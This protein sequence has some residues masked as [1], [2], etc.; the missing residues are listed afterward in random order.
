M[1]TK[2]ISYFSFFLALLVGMLLGA[3]SS[4]E[5]KEP[6]PNETSYSQKEIAKVLPGAWLMI[7]DDHNWNRIDFTRTNNKEGSYVWLS[8]QSQ[9]PILDFEII[10]G[11][12]SFSSSKQ[13]ETSVFL[14]PEFGSMES[15][16]KLG[17]PTSMN[18]LEITWKFTEGTSNLPDKQKTCTF[19]RILATIFGVRDSEFEIDLTSLL[20]KKEYSF[21]IPENQ[22]I[23]TMDE[24]SSSKI[25]IQGYG[26][27]YIPVFTEDGIG[28][29]EVTGS[30]ITHIP[31][32]VSDYY[33]I[34]GWYDSLE[35]FF[36]N[37]HTPALEQQYPGIE[38][39]KTYG[40][41]MTNTMCLLRSIVVYFNQDVKP[42]VMWLIAS[43]DNN[44]TS[45][46]YNNHDMRFNNLEKDLQITLFQE[47]R[48]LEF[49]YLGELN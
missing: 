3:C 7:D 14:V 38:E 39:I 20:K 49:L 40:K 32:N 26:T 2:T 30:P 46:P 34:L 47:K 33:G 17:T 36:W 45:T 24:G 19:H 44:L 27:T 4:D 43:R 35:G 48:C 13:P 9:I 12:W 6:K 10:K 22:D 5:P 16:I 41:F 31:F 25:R 18:E 29:I 11:N 37:G 28:F 1:K 23:V 8:S 15:N 21:E 42:Y